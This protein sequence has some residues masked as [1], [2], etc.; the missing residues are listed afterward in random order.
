MKIN[1]FLLITYCYILA[2]GLIGWHLNDALLF[3]V[4]ITM[5]LF[6]FALSIFF[7]KYLFILLLAIS[8]STLFTLAINPYTFYLVQSGVIEQ[9]ISYEGGSIFIMKFP[10]SS[11]VTVFYGSDKRCIGGGYGAKYSC[12]MVISKIEDLRRSGEVASVGWAK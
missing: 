3:I 5:I 2:I 10:D 1:I 7:R 6:Y 12:K 11:M 8:Y 4:C 9:E